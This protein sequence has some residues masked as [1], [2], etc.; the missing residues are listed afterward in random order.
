MARSHDPDA[1]RS[2]VAHGDPCAEGRES[3]ADPPD[4]HSVQ[5]DRAY[6]S[7]TKLASWTES[8]WLRQRYGCDHRR[9]LHSGSSGHSREV[10]IRGGL[11]NES[12]A[13]RTSEFN[14]GRSRNGYVRH[15]RLACEE[16]SREQ[17]QGRD[18][19]NLVRRVSTID[20]ASQSASC[21]ESFHSDES[22]GRWLDGRR[23]VSQ[24]RVQTAEHELYLRSAS[25]SSRRSQMVDK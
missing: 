6:N 20:G 4:S 10:R 22:D 11:R 3:S 16:C 17:R 2:E 12:P 23:L 24:R 13:S 21:V 8:F 19:R 1:R 14:T 9:R 25:D 5:C 18:S 7:R 15:N